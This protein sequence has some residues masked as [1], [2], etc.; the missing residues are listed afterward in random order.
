MTSKIINLVQ[1]L[2]ILSLL[3]YI[4][5]INDK[6]KK[7]KIKEVE[8]IDQYLD[9]QIDNAKLLD[10][11]KSQDDEIQILGSCCANEGL[12]TKDVEYGD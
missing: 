4:V 9:L 10:H 6:N 2:F 8:L 1:F 12:T 5:N 11:I 3:I 7:L